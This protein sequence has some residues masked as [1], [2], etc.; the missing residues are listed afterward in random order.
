MSILYNYLDKIINNFSNNKT[1]NNIKENF[2][3]AFKIIYEFDNSSVTQ[4]DHDEDLS[5]IGNFYYEH[6]KK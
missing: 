1:I 5:N 4:K 3:K 6:I 2:V